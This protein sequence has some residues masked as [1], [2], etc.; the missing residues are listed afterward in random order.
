MEENVSVFITQIAPYPHYYNERLSSKSAD[1][2]L[3][4]DFTLRKST[5]RSQNDG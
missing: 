5:F 2:I 4:V 3:F 1:R